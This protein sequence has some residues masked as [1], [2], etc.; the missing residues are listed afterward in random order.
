M[1]RNILLYQ[2]FIMR[3]GFTLIELIFVIV[4][5][6]VLG[7]V[8]V[9]KYQNLKQHAVA[10]GVIKVV[11]DTLSSA[12]AAYINKKELDGTDAN[13]TDIVALG[14]AYW[15]SE[16]NNTYKYSDHDDSSGNAVNAATITFDPTHRTIR[17]QI[18]CNNFADS[19]TVNKCVEKLN[20]AST[21]DQTIQF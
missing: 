18:D 11:T 10:A 14:G 9:P 15:T 2:E 3:K 4:I 1:D 21:Y 5:I 17:G 8:A 13:L 19:T 6:G 12:P 20:D 16:N 7:A